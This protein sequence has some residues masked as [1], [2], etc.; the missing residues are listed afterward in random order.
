M[1]P[2]EPNAINPSCIRVLRHLISSIML[3]Q[4]DDIHHCRY[5]IKTNSCFL[6]VKHLILPPK[7]SILSVTTAE[8][9]AWHYGIPEMHLSVM[10]FVDVLVPNRR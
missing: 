8:L 4:Y 10:I 6:V 9:P 5:T 1:Q 3:A 2:I 7:K